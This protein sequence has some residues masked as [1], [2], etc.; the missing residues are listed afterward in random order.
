VLISISLSKKWLAYELG[1]FE[2]AFG[3]LVFRKLPTKQRQFC[4]N[5]LN[6]G[7]KKLISFETNT[8]L[9]GQFTRVL[10]KGL[11]HFLEFLSE[12]FS[13]LRE[14][15]VA[16]IDTFLELLLCPLKLRMVP[17]NFCKKVNLPFVG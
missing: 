11:A 15:L 12:L 3:K 10:Q 9:V 13:E 2:R 4:F 5:T 17:R 7:G 6:R 1:S 14:V 8:N 16:E